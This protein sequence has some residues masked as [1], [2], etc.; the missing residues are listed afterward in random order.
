[1]STAT[2][3]S[4]SRSLYERLGKKDCITD[5]V[6]DIVEAHMR[7]PVIKARF[8]PYLEQGEKLHHTKELLVQFLCAGS[9]GTEQ[10]TG[11]DMVSSHTGMNISAAE[12]M[13]AVDDILM[14]L[15]K[16]EIDE[17]TQKDIL[18]IA[19]SLKNQIIGQ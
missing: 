11:S 15:Q 4:Q 2:L 1:M 19:Y 12:Y 7:N 3:T 17:D 18:F 5:L 9:G 14:V 8:L 10:Y 16:H 13:A 6:N